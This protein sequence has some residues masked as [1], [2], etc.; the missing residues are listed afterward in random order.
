MGHPVILAGFLVKL[1]DYYT[2]QGAHFM[3]QVLEFVGVFFV[4]VF[5]FVFLFFCCFFFLRKIRIQY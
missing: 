1:V 3:V 5:V 2:T 4:F